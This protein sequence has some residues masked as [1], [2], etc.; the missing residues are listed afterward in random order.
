MDWGRVVLV[1][2]PIASPNGTKLV[3]V[4]QH[5]LWR[6]QERFSQVEM[7]DVRS[8][9]MR[10]LLEC[11]VVD[12]GE[13]GRTPGDYYLYQ[14]KTGRLFV[15]QGYLGVLKTVYEAAESYWFQ[16][17]AAKQKWPLFKEVFGTVQDEWDLFP[18]G[19]KHAIK[20]IAE[21]RAAKDRAKYLEWYEAQKSPNYPREESADIQQR[22][23]DEELR[24]PSAE[25][26]WGQPGPRGAPGDQG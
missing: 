25:L 13:V 8:H 7:G 21:E 20:R 16:T 22:R 11:Q 18:A 26:P 6:H 15:M 24:E 14:E 9:L 17:Y 5:C 3:G 4:T 2:P 1:L 12:G 19:R 23:S 10:T